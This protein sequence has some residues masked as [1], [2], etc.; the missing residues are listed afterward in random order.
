MGLR[1]VSRFGQLKQWDI[2]LDKEKKI[3]D[4]FTL[5]DLTDTDKQSLNGFIMRTDCVNN[6]MKE[7]LY[8]KMYQLQF[9]KNQIIFK[10]KPIPLWACINKS[11][12]WMACEINLCTKN[13]VDRFNKDFCY[14]EGEER[15]HEFINQ[16]KNP[17]TMN[18]YRK[19]KRTEKFN[20]CNI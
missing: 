11:I 2:S 8:G 19:L 20:E 6:G 12:I 1:A 17:Y 18:I 10:L 7:S 5:N 14:I 13:L 16:Y 9:S 4:K 15:I 3:I